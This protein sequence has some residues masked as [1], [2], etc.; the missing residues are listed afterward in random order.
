MSFIKNLDH[1]T[2]YNYYIENEDDFSI[3]S[4]V[5]FFKT[6]I[7]INQKIDY[8]YERILND[9]YENRG[10]IIPLNIK[11]LFCGVC[12]LIFLKKQTGNQMKHNNYLVSFLK[13]FDQCCIFF[14]VQNIVGEQDFY[15]MLISYNQIQDSFVSQKY[16]KVYMVYCLENLI[17]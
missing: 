6:F 7:Q 12:E 16:F 5:V 9:C 11:Q 1:G 15:Q 3:N 17:A 4:K 13:K 14:N 8:L 2:L 10:F